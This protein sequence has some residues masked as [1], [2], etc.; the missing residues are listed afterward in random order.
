MRHYYRCT[1]A[2][3]DAKRQVSMEDE[4]SVV[5][6]L[7]QHNHEP[8]S[9]TS[10]RSSRARD[11]DAAADLR[12]MTRKRRAAADPQ[13]QP[14]AVKDLCSYVELQG[15][16]PQYRTVVQSLKSTFD[17]YIWVARAQGEGD[18]DAAPGW[19]PSLRLQCSYASC[20]VVK[21]IEQDAATDHCEVRYRGVHCHPRPNLAER[22][23]SD[24]S[25]SRPSLDD[26]C[27][28]LE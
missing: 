17:G 24:E 19:Q 10:E 9:S 18:D 22:D 12:P 8:L 1:H 6:L 23:E 13:D 7:G 14:L 2:G 16:T 3:C 11:E 28:V 25:S 21:D 4:E 15:S 20:P 5:S 26:I 27:N